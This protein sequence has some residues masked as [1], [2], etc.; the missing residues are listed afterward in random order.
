MCESAY[1]RLVN[2][3]YLYDWYNIATSAVTAFA[4]GTHSSFVLEILPKCSM[5]KVDDNNRNCVILFWQRGNSRVFICRRRFSRI[6]QCFRSISVYFCQNGCKMKYEMGC[7][8]IIES[9]SLCIHAT[10]THTTNLWLW[11]RASAG[12]RADKQ[13][14]RQI[15]TANDFMVAQQKIIIFELYQ[16]PQN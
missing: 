11:L 4:Y 1:L 14:D 8:N 16:I 6:Y 10:D 12:D 2:D 9:F 13:A 3:H 7:T 15:H 5:C